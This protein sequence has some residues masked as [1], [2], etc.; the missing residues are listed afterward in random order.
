MFLKG[1]FSFTRPIP[2]DFRES[3]E[4]GPAISVLVGAVSFSC[5]TGADSLRAELDCNDFLETIS[6]AGS[7]NSAGFLAGVAGGTGALFSSSILS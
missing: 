4:K 7:S 3:I 5:L 2:K 6:V 1:L